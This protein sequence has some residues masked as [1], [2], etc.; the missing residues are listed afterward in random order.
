[1]VTRIETEA[2]CPICKGGKL[3][4]PRLG[5]GLIDFNKLVYCS[6][7]GG[8]LAGKYMVDENDRFDQLPGGESVDFPV[9]WIYHRYFCI[10]LGERDPGPCEPQERGVSLEEVTQNHDKPEHYPQEDINRPKEKS[11]PKIYGGVRL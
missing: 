2:E 4:Y 1:M 10:R 8:K 5:N 11:M 6:C 3:L 9:S 7:Q